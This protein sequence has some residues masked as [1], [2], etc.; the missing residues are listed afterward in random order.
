MGG[1]DQ[2][3]LRQVAPGPLPHVPPGPNS[4][5][6]P[7]SNQSPPS[8]STVPGP[9][10]LP[11]DPSSKAERGPSFSPGEPWAGV[12][13]PGLRNA[14]SSS[15]HSPAENWP[16]ADPRK[17]QA[18]RNQSARNAGSAAAAAVSMS[19]LGEVSSS[20]AKRCGEGRNRG[21][22]PAPEVHAGR[23]PG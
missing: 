14:S 12:H 3:Y 10:K 5:D 19:S 22:T 9:P 21:E 17:S 20:F 4:R 7:P 8:H 1:K 2:S 6:I 11:P 18:E 15:G 13:P 16:W 23:L